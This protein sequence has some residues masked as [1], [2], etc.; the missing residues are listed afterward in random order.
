MKFIFLKIS[1]KDMSW[2]YKEIISKKILK[3]NRKKGTS[4]KRVLTV[5]EQ[6][7]FARTYEHRKSI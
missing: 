5:N 6:I 7:L 4:T 3:K 2:G 1:V